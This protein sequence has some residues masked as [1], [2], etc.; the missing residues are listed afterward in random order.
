VNEVRRRGKGK[1]GAL[2]QISMRVPT[3]VWEYFMQFNYPSVETRR[4][5]EEH[6]KKELDKVNTYDNVPPQ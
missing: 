5:L 2:V 6:V 4:V 1:K 3:Y